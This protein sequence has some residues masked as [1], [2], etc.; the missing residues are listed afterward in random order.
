MEIVQVP[1]AR[2]RDA[3]AFV[4]RFIEVAALA[5]PET[6]QSLVNLAADGNADFWIAHEGGKPFGVC[7]SQVL[8]RPKDRVVNVLAIGG[9]RGAT[10]LRKLYGAVKADGMK[11]GAT[12]A[13]MIRING[14]QS[15]F[16]QKP[17]GS[18]YED[19]F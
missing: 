2:A 8:H 14:R 6:P 9:E 16:G 10:W 7:F 15:Y 4:A 1:P 18:Y 3:V 17:A 19:I 5:S 11:Y 12:K 13:T